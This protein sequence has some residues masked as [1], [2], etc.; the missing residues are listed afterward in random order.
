MGLGLAVCRKL[1]ELMG[2]ELIYERRD[3]WSV[4]QI[5]LP[6]ARAEVTDE[7]ALPA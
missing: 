7:V 6:T 2:G 5:T 4:F 3:G 1:T